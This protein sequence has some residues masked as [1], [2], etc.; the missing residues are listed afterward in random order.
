MI[1]ASIR[2]RAPEAEVWRHLSDPALMPAWMPGIASMRALD[3]EP[4]AAGARL[5]F[6]VPRGREGL[7]RVAALEPGRLLVLEAAHGPFSL[8][9][10]Y[11]MRPAGGGEVEVTLR[12]RCAARGWAVLAAPLVRASIRKADRWQLAYLKGAVE[13]AMDLAAARETAAGGGAP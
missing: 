13:R 8:S 3:G 7:A 9:Y 11:A 10:R 6:S 12:A 5:A 1:E 4:L 2:V